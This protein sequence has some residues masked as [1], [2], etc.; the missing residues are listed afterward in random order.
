MFK[1]TPVVPLVYILFTP[2]H[3]KSLSLGRGNS[4]LILDN[5]HGPMC[6]P[7]KGEK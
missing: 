4:V 6:V 1:I 7:K 3:Q 2:E 5:R